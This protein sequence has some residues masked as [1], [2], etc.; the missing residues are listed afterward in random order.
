MTIDADA[1]VL[2]LSTRSTGIIAVFYTETLQNNPNERVESIVF[3]LA[4]TH[5]HTQRE[6]T[7]ADGLLIKTGEKL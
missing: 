4:Q 2:A 7:K 1:W 6:K 3:T 5:T